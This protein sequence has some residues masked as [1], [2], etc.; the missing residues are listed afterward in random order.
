MGR[1]LDFVPRG[2]LEN[3]RKK[4]KPTKKKFERSRT[5][6]ASVD[7]ATSNH[8]KHSASPER[9]SSS[10]RLKAQRISSSQQ[11]SFG[12]EKERRGSG[13]KKSISR[14]PSSPQRRS[15]LRRKSSSP[16]ISLSPKI[17]TRRKSSIKKS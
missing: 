9:K 7:A 11:S 1:T 15:S 4:S 3:K 13:S 2:E 14:S 10:P 12:K 5:R 17:K 8:F 16:A 6:S